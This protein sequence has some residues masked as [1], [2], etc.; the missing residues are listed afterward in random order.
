M[1]TFPLQYPYIPAHITKPKEHKKLF[2]V[3]LQEKGQ[4]CDNILPLTFNFLAMGGVGGKLVFLVLILAFLPLQ[5]SLLSLRIINWWQHRCLSCMT[6]LLDMGQSFRV[7]H[8]FW[9]GNVFLLSKSACIRGR[10]YEDKPN[11]LVIFK[12]GQVW[13]CEKSCLLKYRVCGSLS[14][15]PKFLDL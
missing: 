6:M 10:R 3:Q 12:I 4:S 14:Q 8:S 9:A 15:L 2:L 13:K 11:L 7:Y 5:R 1:N